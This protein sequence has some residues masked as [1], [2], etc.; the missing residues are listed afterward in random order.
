MS[1]FAETFN[2]D[3]EAILLLDFRQSNNNFHDHIS[4]S[5]LLSVIH[6]YCPGQKRIT[7]RQPLTLWAWNCLSP[8]HNR[9]PRSSEGP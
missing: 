5:P 7:W 1:I 2:H 3:R 8:C 6:R 9:H 4:A